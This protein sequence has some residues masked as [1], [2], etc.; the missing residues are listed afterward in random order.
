MRFL[1]SGFSQ[2]SI[3]FWPVF[4]FLHFFS[5]SVSNSTSYSN[6]KFVLR[7]GPLG[8]GGAHFFADIMDLIGWC[9]PSLVL[10]IYLHFLA[11]LSL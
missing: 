3:P 7:Y 8:G 10:F 6:S 5:N 2:Q 11:S 1:S 9:R 4:T